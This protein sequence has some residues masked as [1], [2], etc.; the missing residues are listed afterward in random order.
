MDLIFGNVLGIYALTLG[1]LGYFLSIVFE[2]F[3]KINLI[4]AMLISLL[5]SSIIIFMNSFVGYFVY[6]IVSTGNIWSSKYIPIILYTCFATVPLYLFNRTVSYF[7]RE[8][9]NEIFRR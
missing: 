8:R 9:K 3:I 5:V 7:T 1:I 4:S 6:G 2:C